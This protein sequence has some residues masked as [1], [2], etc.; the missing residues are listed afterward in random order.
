LYTIHYLRILQ[1]VSHKPTHHQT[2]SYLNYRSF[3]GGESW[4]QINTQG[5]IYTSDLSYAP[6]S[7]TIFTTGAS[8]AGTGSSVSFDGGYNWTGIDAGTQHTAVQFIDENTGWSGGFNYS[9]TQ[10]GIFVWDPVELSIESLDI[11]ESITFYPNPVVDILNISYSKP[12]TTSVFDISGKLIMETNEK[13]I[14][15]SNLKSGIYFV[16]IDDD[17]KSKVIKIIKE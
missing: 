10:G 17:R 3:N 7:N 4:E 15:F 2:Q 5:P 13:K 16:K 8:S 6:N 9:E 11:N 12:F 1:F 14:D